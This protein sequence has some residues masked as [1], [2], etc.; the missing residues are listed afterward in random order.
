MKLRVEILNA[1]GTV[2]Q[3]EEIEI[4]QETLDAI[5]TDNTLSTG[6]I[7][8]TFVAEQPVCLSTITAGIFRKVNFT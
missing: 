1:A 3:A 8:L 5:D 7:R 6:H 2:Y 4:T